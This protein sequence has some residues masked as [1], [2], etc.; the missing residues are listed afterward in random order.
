MINDMHTEDMILL[1][2]QLYPGGETEDAIGEKD[3]FEFMK[4]ANRD[5]TAH[6]RFIV[7]TIAIDMVRINNEL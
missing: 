5:L 3:F 7:L 1:F 4:R 2:D 6:Q